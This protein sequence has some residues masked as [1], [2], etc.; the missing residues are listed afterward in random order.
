MRKTTSTRDGSTKQSRMGGGGGDA[1]PVLSWPRL[2]RRWL[3]LWRRTKPRSPAGPADLFIARARGRVCVAEGRSSRCSGS[4]ST[5][6]LPS[7]ARDGVPGLG[8]GAAGVVVSS[9]PT[10]AAPMPPA[11]SGGLTTG[12]LGT[13]QEVKFYQTGCHRAVNPMARHQRWGR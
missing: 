4:A 5:V 6:R 7:R 2:C 8:D 3:A 11:G 12:G 1:L 13:E 10:A 9:P